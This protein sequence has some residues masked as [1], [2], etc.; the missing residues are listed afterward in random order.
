[1]SNGETYRTKD[2][3]FYCP[4]CAENFF[5]DNAEK[6]EVGARKIGPNH[7]RNK[8]VECDEC[9]QDAFERPASMQLDSVLRIPLPDAVQIQVALLYLR[10]CLAVGV[11]VKDQY[12]ANVKRSEKYSKFIQKH[13]EAIGASKEGR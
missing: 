10:D 9:G 2:G 8:F 7:Y 11:L 13:L 6:R 5:T 4:Q 12:A 3:I 1:M